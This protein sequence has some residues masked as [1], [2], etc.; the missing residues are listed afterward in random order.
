MSSDHLSDTLILP[1]AIPV[2]D[3]SFDR[4]S[5]DRNVRRPTD[6][7]SGL[8]PRDQRVVALGSG[9]RALIDG[10]PVALVNLSLSG[11]QLR[12]PLRV[13]PDQPA[14]VKIGWPQEELPCTAL[15][16]VRWV[17]FEPDFSR[18]ESLYRVGI[19]FEAWDVRSLR[20]IIRHL[21][22]GGQR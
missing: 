19:A 11:A 1:L 10:N 22:P 6:S 3:S 5:P 20:E 15:A 8:R 18:N 12:G 16:R 2:L 17:Q 21:R 7:R 13:R 14:I 4:R 9:Y